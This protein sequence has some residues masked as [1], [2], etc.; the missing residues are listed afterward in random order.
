MRSSPGL[1]SS[2]YFITYFIVSQLLLIPIID[3]HALFTGRQFK[4]LRR[5]P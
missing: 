3:W 5:T 1:E 4:W 2:P